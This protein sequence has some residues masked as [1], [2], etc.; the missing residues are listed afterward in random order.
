MLPLMASV[1]TMRSREWATVLIA[2]CIV[3]PQL[4]VAVV[5]PW[6]GR[7]AEKWGRWPLL[8]AGFAALAIRGAFFI[9]VAS[10]YLLVAVQLLDG[11]SAAVIG[12]MLPLVVSDITRGTGRFNAALGVVGTAGAIGAT[13]STTLAGYLSDDFGSPL[14]FACLAGIAAAGALMVAGLMPET[15]PT[16]D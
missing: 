16:R 3:A 12:V 2:A 13:L 11:V 8:L 10:P 1:V 14:A 15:R 4:L 6:I 5:S 7:Q 9:F